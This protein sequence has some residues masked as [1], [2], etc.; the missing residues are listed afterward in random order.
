MSDLLTAHGMQKSFG[1]FRAVDGVDLMIDAG[2]RRAVIGPNGAGKTTLFN[3]LTG[4]IAIDAGTVTLDGR[5]ITGFPPHEIARYGVSRAFQVT[6]IF[7]GLTVRRN[8]QVALLAASK[9]TTTPWGSAWSQ[10]LDDAD[11]ILDEVGLSRLAET[12][13]GMLSH[14]DQRALELAIA[15]ALGPRL[16]I[17]D[18]P[19]AGMAPEET[20]KTMELIRRIVAER[21]ITLLF[22]EHDMEVVFGTADRV[23]VMNQGS[24]LAEGSPDEVRRDERV[25][26]VY[27]G[28]SDVEG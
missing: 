5:D 3:L 6:S 4:L 21:N 22:S 8:V 27:L 23:T 25:R 18:E 13:A 24:V 26:E 12:Q 7:G 16:L 28:S 15:L 10:K 19:T 1:G 2:E 14:G 9:I 20:S 11:S 17:L